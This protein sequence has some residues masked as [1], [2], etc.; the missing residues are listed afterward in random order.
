MLRFI[1]VL[2]AAAV[3]GSM[4]ELAIAQGN[5]RGPL[6]GAR[7][8]NYQLQIEAPEELVEPLRERTLLGRWREDPGFGI[9]QLPLFLERG[10][11]EAVAV[12]QAAGFFSA[13]ARVLSAVMPRVAMMCRAASTSS[14]L[15][16]SVDFRSSAMRNK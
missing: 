11:E 9:E 1:A 12:A 4:P 10:R 16:A 6:G 7:T 15:R 8:V 3:L 5:L 14:T 13:S 2:W